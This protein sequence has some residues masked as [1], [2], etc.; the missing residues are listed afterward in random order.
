MPHHRRLLVVASL[1]V[2]ALF[3]TVPAI[4]GTPLLCFPFDT[5][6]AP[7]LPMSG[8]GWRAIDPGYDVSRLVADTVRLL[9]PPAPVIARME[10]MRRATIYAAAHPKIA[11]LLLDTL[12]RRAATKDANAPQ[13]IFD[14]GYLAETYKQAKWMFAAPVNGLDAIDGSVWVMKAYALQRDPSMQYAAQLIKGD[15]PPVK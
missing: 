7:S 1:V 2:A 12:E 4:A 11:S 14:F 8:T 15:A 5:G 10:T 9:A 3:S 6:G 13:A